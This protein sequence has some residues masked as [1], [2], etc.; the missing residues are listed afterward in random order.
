MLHGLVTIGV[1]G[2]RL[3]GWI[4]LHPTVYF[5]PRNGLHGLPEHSPILAAHYNPKN[6]VHGHNVCCVMVSWA[7]HLGLFIGESR[8]HSLI[9]SWTDYTFNLMDTFVSPRR[10]VAVRSLSLDFCLPLVHK[11]LPNSS[12][13]GWSDMG[14]LLHIVLLPFCRN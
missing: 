10:S 7:N 6:V 2:K 14:G 12:K 13:W 5:Y 11:L 4:L 8:P 9:F 3:L 1:I